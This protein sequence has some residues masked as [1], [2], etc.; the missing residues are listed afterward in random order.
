M[1]QG[2]ALYN[3]TTPRSDGF[4]R[5]IMTMLDLNDAERHQVDRRVHKAEARLARA[6][7]ST[8]EA[9]REAPANLMASSLR[10][11]GAL[12][13]EGYNHLAREEQAA[14]V[15]LLQITKAVEAAERVLGEC[16]K[17]LVERLL[18]SQK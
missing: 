4:L 13:G 12:F 6:N 5:H 18:A 8:R 9:M 17:A 2:V 7:A 15:A 16:Q 3:R 10:S 11:L 14:K 1:K